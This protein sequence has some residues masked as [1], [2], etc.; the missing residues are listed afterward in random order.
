MTSDS[1]AVKDDIGCIS[2]NSLIWS[3]SVDIPTFDGICQK[4]NVGFSTNRKTGAANQTVYTYTESLYE[5]IRLGD[6]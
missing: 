6:D 5:G 1:P 4:K 3:S 2:S